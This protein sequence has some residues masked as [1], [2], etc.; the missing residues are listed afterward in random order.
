M[1]RQEIAAAV[2][3]V[4]YIVF[5]SMPPPAIVSTVLNNIVGMVA[6]VAGA[7]YVTLYKSKLVGGLLLLALVLNISRGGREGFN[8]SLGKFVKASSS[9]DTVYFV[10]TGKQE[11][12]RLSGCN[13]CGVENYCTNL[14]RS[15]TKVQIEA[16]VDKGAFLCS[17]ISTSGGNPDPETGNNPPGWR[18]P[19]SGEGTGAGSGGGTGGGTGA[20]SGGGTGGGSGGGTGGGTGGGETS[21]VA[22][23]NLETFTT[24][25]PQEYAPF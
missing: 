13:Q 14:D 3:V 17:M 18:P 12:Y 24:M 5:F 20:G 2:A 21:K 9:D 6:C 10:P 1:S 15:M 16:L 22:S 19:S 25:G 8:A 4:L 11:R 7:V 23:C